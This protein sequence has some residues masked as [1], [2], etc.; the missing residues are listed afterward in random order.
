MF[1][2][3]SGAMKEI[4]LKEKIAFNFIF[5]EKRVTGGTVVGS[6]SVLITAG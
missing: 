5:N 4:T 6:C 1:E 3:K 2:K